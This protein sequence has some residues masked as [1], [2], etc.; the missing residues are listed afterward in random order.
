MKRRLVVV[1]LAMLAMLAPA[2]RAWAHAGEEGVPA[3]D[4]V[5]EA[6]AIIASEPNLTDTIGDKINDAI[7]SND[8]TSVDKSLVQQAQ[9]VFESGDLEQTTLLLEE[10]VGA[11]PGQPVV[12]PNEGPRLPA[13]SLP[14]AGPTSHLLALGGQRPDGTQ[15]TVVLGFAVILALGGA[16][17]A[18]RFR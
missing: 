15:T 7:D 3:K 14:S 8:Q 11:R 6:I 17:T 13:A 2:G 9:A 10:S 16:L 12:N 5:E 1:V 4:S 18:R